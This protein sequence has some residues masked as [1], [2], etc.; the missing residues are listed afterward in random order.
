MNFE[1]VLFTVE[2]HSVCSTLDLLG[3]VNGSNGATWVSMGVLSDGS[4]YDIPADI[5]FSF[6]IRCPGG[7]DAEIIDGVTLGEPVRAQIE[8]NVEELLAEKREVR[9]LLP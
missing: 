5:V 1:E 3:S 8:R 9:D 2:N 4:S 7:G 6:P